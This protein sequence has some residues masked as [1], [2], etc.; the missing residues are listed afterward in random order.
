[1]Q[2][3]TVRM[4]GITIVSIDGEIDGRTAPQLEAG[5]AS[6]PGRD[7]VV[8]DLSGVSY[9]SSAG[10]RALL[11]IHRRVAG[12]NGRL[13]LAGV[14]STVADTMKVTGFL[15]YFVLLE[16]RADAVAAL[17]EPVT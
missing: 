4:D 9:L 1:M 14:A 15:R 11:L 6:W 7:R 2:V 3:Q 8:L 16:T 12:E 13:V 17:L 10:L 5:L